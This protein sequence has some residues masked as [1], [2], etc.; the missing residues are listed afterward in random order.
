MGDVDSAI[1]E[2]GVAVKIDPGSA[3]A[4]YNLAEAYMIKGLN[5]EAVLYLKKFLRTSDPERDAELRRKAMER[6]STLEASSDIL[7]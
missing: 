1:K 2:L 4:Y 7:P 6:I 3:F 5:G